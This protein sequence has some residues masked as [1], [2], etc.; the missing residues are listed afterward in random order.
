MNLARKIGKLGNY[1]LYADGLKDE[2]TLNEE[3]I[4]QSSSYGVFRFLYGPSAGG[5]MESIG[6]EIV[7]SGENI[8]R[9][10]PRLYKSKK[11]TMIGKQVG[12]AMFTVERINAAFSASHAAAF[13]LASSKEVD[14]FL[15]L[16]MIV[17][18]E[19]ERIR[20]N[21]HVI[22]RMV[23]ASSQGV[24]SN[25][26][27]YLR[28]L[29]NR[30]IDRAYGHRFFFNSDGNKLNGLGTELNKIRSQ[31]KIAFDGLLDTR[32]FIDRLDKN[33][34]I[35]HDDLIGPAARA[36]GLNH[37]ARNEVDLPYSDLG[38]KTNINLQMMEKR[39]DALGRFL[40]RSGEI[41]FSIDL[42]ERAL[43]I[44]RGRDY[45]K[46]IVREGVGIGR[47]ESPSGDLA[48]YVKIEEGRLK[49]IYLL[50]PSDINIAFFSKSIVNNTFTDFQFNWESF[51]IWA[52]E[53]GVS[54]L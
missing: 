15:K 33:G 17:K 4:E 13:L 20:N 7:T 27:F 52:S 21:L 22:G 51:G 41:P 1:M 50:S 40:I 42:I 11:F 34:V 26:I 47:V 30:T 54:F 37:D 53:M 18:M 24:A 48:Y 43:D 10:K 6:F 12:D 29:V 28:E 2:P 23:D 19:L 46:P 8:I 5:L 32:I 25:W 38:F 14:Y 45:Q 35:V 9:V 49:E 31:F 3:N 39:G 16:D 36:A 44:L